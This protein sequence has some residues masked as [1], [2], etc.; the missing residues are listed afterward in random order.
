MIIRHRRR[1]I[2]LAAVVATLVACLD[3]PVAPE[4]TE[5]AAGARC[6][7][8]DAF[9]EN[10]APETAAAVSFGVLRGLICRSGS[11]TAEDRDF[12]ALRGTADSSYRAWLDAPTA[13]LAEMRLF[14]AST[15]D[16]VVT[17]VDGNLRM[18]RSGRLLAAVR[19][20]CVKPGDSLPYTLLLNDR[21]NRAPV[22]AFE[23]SPLRPIA[24]RAVTLTSKATDPD[25][26]TLTLRRWRLGDGRTASGAT[27][28]TSWPVR[29]RY[30]LAHIVSDQWGRADS[31]S[32]DVIVDPDVARIDVTPSAA[33]LGAIG[34][35]LVLAAVARDPAG[36]VVTDVAFTWKS[37]DEAIAT[38]SPAGLVV[39]RANGTVQVSA[40]AYGRTGVA[41]VTV[42]QKVHRIVVTPAALRFGALGRTA[43]VAAR[44]EDSRGVVVAGAV[45]VWS[46]TDSLVAAVDVAGKVT[47]RRA[48]TATVRA[49][50]GSVTATVSVVVAPVAAVI[51][52]T[53]STWT[54][55]AASDSLL[56][57]AVVRDSG[58]A[59]I[60]DAVVGWGTTDIARV[61]VNDQGWAF[62]VATG[63]ADVVATSAPAS[64]SATVTV[65]LPAG[66]PPS[67]PASIRASADTIWMPAPYTVAPVIS[68]RLFN[69]AGDTIPIT[70][71]LQWNIEGNRYHSMSWF[72]IPMDDSVKV[73]PPSCVGCYERD[74]FRVIVFDSSYTVSDTVVVGMDVPRPWAD[75][76]LGKSHSC[77][78]TPADFR[79][80]F[81]EIYCWGDNSYGQL[82]QPAGMS[83]SSVPI[84]FL[85]DSL[86]FTDITAGDDF[87]CGRTRASDVYCWG[88]NRWGQLGGATSDDFCSFAC[89]RTAFKVEGVTSGDSRLTA[90]PEHVCTVSP[91]VLCW[92]RNQSGQL[93]RDPLL[94]TWSSTPASVAGLPTGSSWYGA[95]AL[96]ATTC[97][98]GTTQ[99][100]CVGRNANGEFGMNST[101]DSWTAVAS[102]VPYAT[103]ADIFQ[104]GRGSFMCGYQRI[105]ATDGFTYL[106]CWGR[107]DLGQTG[108]PAGYPRQ[109]CSGVPC[110]TNGTTVPLPRP[111]RSGGPLF[112]GIMGPH[113][114]GANFACTGVLQPSWVCWGDNSSGQFGNGTTTGSS[115]PSALISVPGGSAFGFHA[116]WAGSSNMCVLLYNGG[117]HCMGSGL[118]GELGNGTRLNSLVPSRVIDP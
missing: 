35:S 117:L 62:P 37:A 65:A 3:L 100:H 101:S 108:L 79:P 21:P 13:T 41:S 10:D 74:V 68:A 40:E 103:I 75:V 48:G 53:P 60:A 24:G 31:S 6:T 30:A 51:D 91:A 38:V 81:N 1:L 110:V 54:F 16:A 61:R 70:G 71:P 42:K 82:G 5:S 80:G 19:L 55:T 34:D 106:S 92:G 118:N 52:L 20:C 23:W 87:T 98:S 97:F 25:G 89:S 64:A 26:D 29:G 7:P 33:E 17:E 12:F 47:A 88:L 78:L 85:G 116:M 36:A 113:A 43:T 39:A 115:T 112:A 15:G 96:E 46:S 93:G 99:R 9:E 28:S 11:D 66:P 4:A 56:F 14:D 32:Q 67:T 72:G 111:Q 102:G 77:G 49:S 114:V 18:P 58:G 63:A 76:A 94:V 86:D 22:A 50:I 83:N 95:V 107:D 105:A 84:R 57:A 27:V 73:S 69:A 104:A 59:I 44:V 109:V 2:A 45:P 90:G 8:D